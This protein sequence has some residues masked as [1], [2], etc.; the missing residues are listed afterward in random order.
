MADSMVEWLEDI[1]MWIL[2]KSNNQEQLL[3]Y[4]Q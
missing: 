3:K 4:T 2:S 1:L